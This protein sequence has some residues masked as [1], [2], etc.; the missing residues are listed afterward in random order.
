MILGS[1]RDFAFGDLAI[2]G[3]DDGNGVGAKGLLDE[4][5][6]ALCTLLGVRFSRCWGR[7]VHVKLCKLIAVIRFFWVEG[8]LFV[9]QCDAIEDLLA[10][11]LGYPVC[12]KVGGQT[13]RG[14][15]E[16]WQQ[17]GLSWGYQEPSN[18]K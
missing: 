3:T 10:C 4:V 5:S 11:C 15:C 6:Q 12:R 17:S 9:C 16:S 13:E 2:I 8:T 14:W 18:T 7:V 1:Y